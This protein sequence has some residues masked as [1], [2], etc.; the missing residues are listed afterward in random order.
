MVLA[1][2]IRTA[3]WAGESGPVNKSMANPP[4]ARP[5][6]TGRKEGEVRKGMR[7]RVVGRG[8]GWVWGEGGM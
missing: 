2:F 8:W 5:A 3:V 4:A 1:A 6:E 7:V